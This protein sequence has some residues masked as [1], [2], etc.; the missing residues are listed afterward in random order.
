MTAEVLGHLSGWEF[1]LTD[2]PKITGQVDRFAWKKKKKCKKRREIYFF[3]GGEKKTRPDVM[4]GEGQLQPV[5]HP[6][7]IKE[8]DLETDREKV[9]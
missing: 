9:G 1:S 7:I 8:E 2:V 6:K 3:G 4:Q 5:S